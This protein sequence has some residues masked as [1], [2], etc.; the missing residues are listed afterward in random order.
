MFNALMVSLVL[1]A[2]INAWEK[3]SSIPVRAILDPVRCKN[4]ANINPSMSDN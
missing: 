3:A 2:S 1:T 4:I